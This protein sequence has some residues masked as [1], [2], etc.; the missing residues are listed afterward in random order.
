[1]E[2]ESEKNLLPQESVEVETEQKEESVKDETTLLSENEAEKPEEKRASPKTRFFKL[3]ERKKISSS[4][5]LDVPAKEKEPEPKPTHARTNFSG[6]F[7]KFRR[8]KCK[9]LFDAS[10]IIKLTL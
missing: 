9:S 6:F 5:N 1:M 3:F 4:E 8:G 2:E 10:C 7:N